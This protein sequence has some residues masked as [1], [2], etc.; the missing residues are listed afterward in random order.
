MASWCCFNLS[1]SYHKWEW[2]SFHL[3]ESPWI[4]HPE[5][6]LH[7]LCPFF[8]LFFFVHLLFFFVRRVLCVLGKWINSLPWS[9]FQ[10]YHLSF[11]DFFVLQIDQF[12]FFFLCDFWVVSYCRKVFPALELVCFVF[13]F[14]VH[15]SFQNF[16][17]VLF[18]GFWVLLLGFLFLFFLTFIPWIIQNT[19]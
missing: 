11:T 2:A 5:L 13:G 8:C 6:S 9:K 7:I 19:F 3:P 12:F 14:L 17:E 10:V 18:F 4:S 15:C 16:F 1:V